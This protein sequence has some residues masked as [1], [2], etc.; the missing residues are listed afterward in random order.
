[1]KITI[2]APEFPPATG[3]MEVHALQLSRYLHRVH[4]VKVIAPCLQGDDVATDQIP[5]LHRL[6][7]Q[8]WRSVLTILRTLR[9]DPPDV[10]LAL[11]G[12]YALLGRLTSCPL[13]VRVV[14]NDFYG[15]WVGPHLPLRWLFWRLPV[16][17]AASPGRWLRRADQRFRNRMVAWGLASSRCILAN[18]NFTAQALVR[19]GIHGADVR[20][21]VGGVDTALFQPRPRAAARVRLGL[22]EGP[23]VATFGHL[24]A[25]KGIDTALEAV[26]ILAAQHRGLTYL[27]IGDGEDEAQL[28]TQARSLGV[29]MQV[30]FLGR[31]AHAELPHYLAACDVYLQSS[32]TAYNPITGVPDVETMGR[33]ACEASACGIPVVATDSGGLPDVVQPETTGLLVPENQPEVM[34]R[35]IDRLLQDSTLRERMGRQG[36]AY[37]QQHFSW[38]TVGQRTEQ[39]LRAAAAAVA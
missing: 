10:V 4:D 11:N 22:P 27:V 5:V 19:A 39:A 23:I 36:A 29:G 35:A 9:E 28:R 26:R 33:A 8:F 31:K 37:A 14:G 1:M 18:S 6:R 20:V 15:S 16:D 32:R 34:A 38:E 3:G 17:G 12:G 24:K 30:H 2:V 25:K 7:R 13:V 21:I